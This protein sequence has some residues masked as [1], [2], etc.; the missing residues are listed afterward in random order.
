M[1]TR[2][3]AGLTSTGPCFRPRAWLR[4]TRGLIIDVRLNGGG[5]EPLSQRV[6]GRFLEKPFVYAY[7]QFRNG[8][9]HTNLTDKIARRLSPRGPWRYDRPVV[10]LIGQKCMSSNESFI[11]MMSG[12]TNVVIM[13]DHTCGSSGNPQMTPLALDL[14]VS[15]PKWVDYLPDGT[16]LDARGRMALEYGVAPLMVRPGR[17]IPTRRES[18]GCGRARDFFP[19]LAVFSRIGR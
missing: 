16:P 19:L 5:A 13:G 1:T 18:H 14:T 11:A 7:H 6:A 17:A 8:P 10:L 12:G 9:Q 4:D 15:V 3:F 2:E